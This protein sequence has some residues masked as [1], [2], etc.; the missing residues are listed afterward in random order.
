MTSVHIEDRPLQVWHS[1]K[2]FCLSFIF[3][4]QSFMDINIILQVRESV[5]SQILFRSYNASP[6]TGTENTVQTKW[7]VI[8]QVFIV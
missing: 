4:S 6:R 2:S 8:R 3:S 1:F 7:F 5:P